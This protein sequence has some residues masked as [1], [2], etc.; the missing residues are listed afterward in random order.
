MAHQATMEGKLANRRQARRAVSCVQAEIHKVGVDF[1]IPL[2][3]SQVPERC[4]SCWIK[5]GCAYRRKPLSHN[6]LSF[7]FR[8]TFERETVWRLLSLE[9]TPCSSRCCALW[10]RWRPLPIGW[11]PYPPASPLLSSPLYIIPFCLSPS[12][13]F[14]QVTCESR[15]CSGG[16]G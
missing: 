11:A 4:K 9:A 10:S 3:V 2:S 7:F 6:A 14:L 8:C 13:P 12:P 16:V 5:V 1:F 15:H